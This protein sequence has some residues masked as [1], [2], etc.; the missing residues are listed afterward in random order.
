[1]KVKQSIK[2]LLIAIL[3]IIMTSNFILPNYS[4]AIDSKL[5]KPLAAFITF[6]GDGVENGLQKYFI[7]DKAI[8]EV[9]NNDGWFETT[10]GGTTSLYLHIKYSV[11]NIVSGNIPMFDINFFGEGRSI[12]IHKDNP[13]IRFADLFYY[14]YVYFVDGI[15][16]TAETYGIDSQEM[17]ELE[18]YIRSYVTSQFGIQNTSLIKYNSF[19]PEEYY[20]QEYKDAINN[21]RYVS[22]SK[23]V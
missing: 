7:G 21:R 18:E 11:A 5:G 9:E 4:H 10:L 17:A 20:T 3:A 12:Y 13:F 22:K 15:N 19:T 2:K 14:L 8:T 6:L 1:M 23:S 16:S